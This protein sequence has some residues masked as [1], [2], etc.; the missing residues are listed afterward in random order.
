MAPNSCR[1]VS[2]SRSIRY[3]H[4]SITGDSPRRTAIHSH[5]IIN[6]A[7]KPAWCKDLASID[8]GLYRRFY[9]QKNTPFAGAG[10]RGISSSSMRFNPTELATTPQRPQADALR[11]ASRLAASRDVRSDGHFT[12]QRI[13]AVAAIALPQVIGDLGLFP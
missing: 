5:S 1:D 8:M 9:R 7:P 10:L 12:D 6:Q 2:L 13:T 3:S 11:H 4:F